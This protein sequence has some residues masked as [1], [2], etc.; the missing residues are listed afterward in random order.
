MAV[1][2]NALEVNHW[3]MPEGGYSRYT[4]TETQPLRFELSLDGLSAERRLQVESAL[5]GRDPN[6]L[7]LGERKD[8][9]NGLTRDHGW[10]MLDLEAVFGNQALLS[11]GYGQ[12]ITLDL[13]SFE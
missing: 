8:L 11:L 6:S 1:T 3:E 9:I 7:A 13:P 5:C 10:S 4:Y 2:G 12:K